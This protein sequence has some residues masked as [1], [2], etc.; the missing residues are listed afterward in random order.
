MQQKSSVALLP[1]P[2]L[3]A[4]PFGFPSLSLRGGGSGKGDVEEE[5]DAATAAAAAAAAS[6]ACCSIDLAFKNVIISAAEE[7]TENGFCC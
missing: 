7:N 6:F 3:P 4:F 5:D 1:P 2:L